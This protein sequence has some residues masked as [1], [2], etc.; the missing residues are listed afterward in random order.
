MN[1]RIENAE[2]FGITESSLT[3]YFSVEADG[4]P[5]DEPATVRVDG[6]T[7]FVSEGPGTRHVEIDGLEPD[8]EYRL[9]IETTGGVTAAHD[10]PFPATARTLP[11]PSGD[12]VA[13]SGAPEEGRRE[14][15]PRPVWSAGREGD[16]QELRLEELA[17]SGEAPFGVGRGASDQGDK[18][19]RRRGPEPL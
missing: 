10:Q 6:E 19:P 7:R 5:V 13:G 4:N 18:W 16:P 8:T 17:A 11:G 9:E 15:A 1:L 14:E 3:L 12:P 2:L